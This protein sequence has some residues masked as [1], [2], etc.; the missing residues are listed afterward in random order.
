MKLKNQ[1]FALSLMATIASAVGCT[2]KQNFNEEILAGKYCFNHRDDRDSLFLNADNTYT[3]KFHTY[4]NGTFDENGTWSFD[5]ATNQVTFENFV[6]F[7]EEGADNPP[8]I[9]HS[10]V[11]VTKDNEVR[12]LYAPEHQ[13]YYYKK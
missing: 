5:A 11:E 3:H 13:V 4:K 2:Q 12:L 1:L 8:G 6:F 9:W 7:N 10:T